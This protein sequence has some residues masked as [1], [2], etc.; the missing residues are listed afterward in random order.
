MKPYL[1]ALRQII[2]TGVD[3]GGRNGLTRALFG[4]QMRYDMADG[5]PTVTTKRLYWKG[6]VHELLWFISGSTNVKYLREHGIKWWDAWADENGEIGPLYGKQLRNIEHSY[7]V[8]PL[9]YI[10][11]DPKA[12]PPFNKEIKVD[13]NTHNTDLLGKTVETK[14]GL[15]TV[16]KELPRHRNGRTHFIVKFH[17]T[18]YEREATYDS[19]RR[20][21]LKDLWSPT[22]YGVGIYGDYDSNDEDLNILKNTWL[23]VIKRCYDINSKSYKSYGEKGVHVSPEWLVF[24]NFQRDAKMLPNWELKKQF[25]DEYS[26]DK[27]ILHASN[28]YSY[29]TCMWASHTEQS[30]NTSTS[31][32]FSAISPHGDMV[33]FRSFGEARKKYNLNASAIHRCLAGKLKTHH[34]WSGF[35]YLSKDSG[36]LRTRIID[37]LKQVIAQIRHNPYSRR[38]VISLWNPHDLDKMSLPPCHGT[39]IQFYVENDKLSMQMYQRSCDLIIGVPVN[40]AS[41]SL[42]LHMVAQVTDLVPGEFIHTLGDAHIYHVHFEQVETQLQREPLEL[43]ELY[44]NPQITTIDNFKMQDIKLRNYKHHGTIKAPMVV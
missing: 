40:I 19:I 4:M 8:E 20:G 25:P 41:Y 11:P 43:P 5:F 35:R 10:P 1:D 17:N 34:G 26:L 44:L 12:S 9:I 18:G 23:D 3:R 33:V 22:V 36:V 30:L 37:Q 24:A 15:C 39:V 38:H 16:I 7:W 6:V 29:K 14:A 42:L 27:D 32:L 28:R 13:F 21:T 31:T 2:E